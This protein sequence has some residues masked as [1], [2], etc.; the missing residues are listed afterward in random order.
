MSRT[1]KDEHKSDG[2]NVGR[3]LA[4]Q[5]RPAGRM[6]AVLEAEDDGPED[7]GEDLVVRFEAPEDPGAWDFEPWASA[8]WCGCYCRRCL[9][10]D[11]CGGCLEEEG[12]PWHSLTA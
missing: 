10:H 5:S 11:D 7:F 8:D 6:L 2:W 9:L 12:H 3:R 4:R 1:L